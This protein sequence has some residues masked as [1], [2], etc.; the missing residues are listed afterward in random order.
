MRFATRREWLKS[1]LVNVVLFRRSSSEY[2]ASVQTLITSSTR[3]RFSPAFRWSRSYT[4]RYPAVAYRTLRRERLS[5]ASPLASSSRERSR[6]CSLMAP[7]SD[8][9]GGTRQ[10]RRTLYNEPQYEGVTRAGATSKNAVHH[11]FALYFWC[12]QVTFLL[13]YLPLR[14]AGFRPN[15]YFIF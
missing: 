1:S 4:S 6:V 5:L 8:R 15:D 9:E 13:C 14:V 2:Q 7:A 11:K 3:L 12:N 10:P